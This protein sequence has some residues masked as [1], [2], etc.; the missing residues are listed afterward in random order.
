MAANLPYLASPASIKIALEK[1]KTAATPDRVTQEFI[2]TKLQIKGGT[3]AAIPPFLK[4]IG[5][6]NSDGSPSP[7]YHKFRN[8]QTAG[9][10]IAE[11]IKTGYREMFEVNEYCYE[12][13]DTEL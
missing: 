7:L 5:L 11:A 10:A 2:K 3:G 1:I 9:S 4:K 12:M 13:N 8:S 6:V